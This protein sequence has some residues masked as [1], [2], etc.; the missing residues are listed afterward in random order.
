MLADALTNIV[1]VE[2]EAASALLE[3]FG[4]A[5]LMV[6]RD[7]DIRVTTSWQAARAA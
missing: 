6:G 2:G 5:A 7:G 1:M 3:H 4:A